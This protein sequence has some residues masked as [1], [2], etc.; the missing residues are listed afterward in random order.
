MND[1]G[2]LLTMI[3]Y[4]GSDAGREAYDSMLVELARLRAIEA[5]VVR[6]DPSAS[7][8]SGT[9]AASQ[10]LRAATE[11][12]AQS[13]LVRGVESLRE[14]LGGVVPTMRRRIA[15]LETALEGA[16][17]DGAAAAL[18]IIGMGEAIRRRRDGEAIEVID[19]M[20]GQKRSEGT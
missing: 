7:C 2:K 8:T 14:Y 19:Q 10:V 12:A 3:R 16:Y 13:G 20:A 15:D 6:V 1:E 5:S 17:R 11:E 9:C 18:G 4:A